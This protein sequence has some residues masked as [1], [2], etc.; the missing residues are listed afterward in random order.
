MNQKFKLGLSYDDVLLI[1]SYSKVSSRKEVDLTV[2]L[3]PRLTLK[4]PVISA[5]MTDVTGKEMA[6]TLGKLGGL[7]VIPRF[8]RA[9]DEAKMVGEVK[10][11]GVI[12]AASVG[13]RNGMFARAEMLV[14]AGADVLF[15]DVAHGHMHNAIVATQSLRQK[16]GRSV[17]IISG[18][19]A[20]YEGAVALYKSG[21]DC[22]KVGVGPGSI[23]IT[24]QETGV[25]VPQLTAVL[26]TARAAKK[27]KKTIIADGGI[28]NSGDIVKAL[29]AGASAVMAGNLFAGFDE[30]PGE[31]VNIKGKPYRNYYASTSFEEKKNHIRDNGD[32]LDAQYVKHIEGVAGLVPYKGSVIRF[33]E[34]LSANIRSGFSYCGAK[35]IDMLRK[36][37]K[38]IQI[39]SMGLRESGPHDVIT[40]DK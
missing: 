7:G 19:I 29:A 22:V 6:I 1:P 9:E 2:N 36:N 40:S 35:D 8:M 24:R 14:K 39:T 21:A 12:V 30:S 20:T 15:L 26:D 11:T 32:N 16:F 25:G 23:C 31:K 27:F 38:F 10:N 33:L 37:A 5:N 34:R 4:L 17:D 13:L 3:T 28:K 18:N